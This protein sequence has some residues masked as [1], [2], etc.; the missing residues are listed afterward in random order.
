MGALPEDE[1]AA[2]DDVLLEEDNTKTVKAAMSKLGNAVTMPKEHLAKFVATRAKWYRSLG[3]PLHIDAYDKW[4]CWPIGC[5]KAKCGINNAYNLQRAKEEYRKMKKRHNCIA[6]EHEVKV[7]DWK[8]AV[9]K[10]KE[11]KKKE[12]KAKKEEKKDK[13]AKKKEKATKEKEEKEE[14]QKWEAQ[15]A[16]E[17]KKKAAEA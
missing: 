7:A 9:A 2:V 5:V 13:A 14:E 4:I 17:R 10:A 11:L 1:F 16:K 12:K 8:K 15:K 3:A 6:K